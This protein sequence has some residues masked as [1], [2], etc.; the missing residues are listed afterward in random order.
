MFSKADIEHYFIA[1]KNESLLFIILGISAVLLAIIFFFFVKTN[2][3][4]AAALPLFVIGILQFFL[5]Y[6]AYKQSDKDRLQ[7]VYAYDMNPSALKTSELTRVKKLNTSLKIM[8]YA[9][10]ALLLVGLVLFFYLKNDRSHFYSVA[11]ILVIIIEAIICLG[12]TIVYH[13]N[14]KAYEAG[15][16]NFIIK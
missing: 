2:W 4:K 6:T 12:G 13:A 14:T 5:S 15:L 8:Q 16:N 3:N 10:G 7:N 11:F 9:E 1:E